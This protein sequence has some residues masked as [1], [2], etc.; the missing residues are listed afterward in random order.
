[1][2]VWEFCSTPGADPA[3]GCELNHYQP[4]PI[5]IDAERNGTDNPRTPRSSLA[6]HLAS[7][8][9]SRATGLCRDGVGIRGQSEIWAWLP[10]G[11][12]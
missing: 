7:S 12:C 4:S 10:R 5:A 1:M 9:D 6:P 2:R 8:V 11:S 3:G